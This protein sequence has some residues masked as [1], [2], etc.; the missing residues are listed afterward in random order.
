MFV[1]ELS[2][3]FRRPKDRYV[4]FYSVPTTDRFLRRHSGLVESCLIVF[5]YFRQRLSR[6]G[7]PVTRGSL[8]RHG[9]RYLE[10]K[11]LFT[12][13]NQS[14]VTPCSTV[15]MSPVG[16]VLLFPHPSRTSPIHTKI[17]WVPGRVTTSYQ[18]G[19]NVTVR[20][21]VPG[22]WVCPESRV[23]RVLHLGTGTAS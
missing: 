2:T 6:K 12:K 18:D 19:V 16:P 23:L 8:S 3:P 17:R 20:R 22:R 13:S 11:D 15:P 1:L 21:L 9:T 14:T 7:C 4:Q 5:S 10:S